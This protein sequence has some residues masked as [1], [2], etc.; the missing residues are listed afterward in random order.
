MTDYLN[1]D[2]KNEKI[3]LYWYAF[4]NELQNRYFIIEENIFENNYLKSKKGGK[5]L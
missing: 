3:N 4:I 2:T 5:L 1:K